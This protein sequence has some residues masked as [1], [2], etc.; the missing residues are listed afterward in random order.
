MINNLWSTPFQ[1]TKID[2][3]ICDKMVQTLLQEYDLFNAPSDFGSINVLDNPNDVITEFKETV[4][5]PAFD[6]FL[7]KTLDRS[8]EDW[9]GHKIH[10]WIAGYNN[11]YSLTHHNHRGSQLSAVFYLMCDFQDKG[12]AIVFTDP[13]QNANR[14]Y[15]TTFQK[16][17]KPLEI[18]PQSGDIV[19]FPSYLYHY[20]ETYGGNIRLAMPVDLFLFNSQ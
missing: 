8:I 16:W 11:N 18:K 3:S 14:G 10:G 4:V 1:Q 9:K 20:V 13:R 6:S 17:F 12:G 2:D 5:Y 19:V 15:D 7:K